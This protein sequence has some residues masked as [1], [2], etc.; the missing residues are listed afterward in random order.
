MFHSNKKGRRPPLCVGDTG[1]GRPADTAKPFVSAP[2]A[3]CRIKNQLYSNPRGAQPPLN[4]KTATERST[5]G[6][7]I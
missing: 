5:R 3:D 2:R 7:A 4:L 6:V 1:D